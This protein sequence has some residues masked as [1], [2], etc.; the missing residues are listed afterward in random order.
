MHTVIKAKNEVRQRTDEK[1]L[2]LHV[3]STSLSGSTKMKIMVLIH[4]RNDHL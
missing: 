2:I 1:N 4:K 3:I